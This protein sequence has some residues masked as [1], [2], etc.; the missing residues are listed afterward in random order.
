MHGGEYYDPKSGWTNL[1]D[2][3]VFDPVAKVWT[4][5]VAENAPAPRFG[6]GFAFMAREGRLYVH[7]GFGA[8]GCT[9]R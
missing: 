5:L 9:H 1:G 3:H 6:H 8:A 4:D 2:L 7:D